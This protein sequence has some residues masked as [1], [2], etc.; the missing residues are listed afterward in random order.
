MVVAVVSRDGGG[1]FGPTAALMAWSMV[2]AFVAAVFR[3]DRAG[4]MALLTT[5][6]MSATTPS[7]AVKLNGCPASKRPGIGAGGS[8]EEQSA[9]RC[10][11]AAGC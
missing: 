11:P 3:A 8:L 6:P 1:F 7:M 4:T 9:G 10:R 2:Q 5:I